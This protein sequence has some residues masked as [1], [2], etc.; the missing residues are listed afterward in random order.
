MD[1]IYSALNETS[2]EVD[3]VFCDGLRPLL[4]GT[5]SVR[6]C[7]LD[8]VG[9]YTFRRSFTCGVVTKLLLLE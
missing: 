8:G 5:R 3:Y 9:L 2:F 1:T 4:A 7:I 6:D